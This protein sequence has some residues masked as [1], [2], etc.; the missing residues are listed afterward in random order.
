M[1]KINLS[2]L[3][4][5]IFFSTTSFSQDSE[6]KPPQFDKLAMGI[7][8]G[9]DYGGFGFNVS[10]YPQKNIGI[11]AGA[12][13]AIAGLGY[14]LGVKFRLVSK[15]HF[16]PYAVAMY[17]YN[18]AVAVSNSPNYNKIFYGPT[19]GAGFDLG[20]HEQKRGYFS[21]AILIPFRSPDVNN[22]M[23]NLS[24]NNGVTFNNKLLPI[25]ISIGYKFV[26]Y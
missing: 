17:G 21:L 14:N 26:I 8:A 4:L 18:A 22:Y 6:P 23:N 12:G 24:N 13:Y 19:I 1:N 9:F 2:L 5:F 16:T 15:K 3:C 11:F 10:G 25:G 20:S 7:G